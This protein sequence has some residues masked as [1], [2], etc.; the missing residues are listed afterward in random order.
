MRKTKFTFYII[1]FAFH[2]LLFIFALVVDNNRNDLNFL[3][4][5]QSYIPVMKYVAL[6]GLILFLIDFLLANI[7]VRNRLK[8][9]QY[10]E[11]EYNALKA[12]LY[13]YKES[14][15]LDQPADLVDSEGEAQS[16]E[17]QEPQEAE[18]G[19]QG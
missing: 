8:D 9:G 7:A 15:S 3:L 19:N 18:N 12:K 5:L 14:K 11:N 6:A 17:P 4:A 2:L 13:D 1:F 10:W 16:E